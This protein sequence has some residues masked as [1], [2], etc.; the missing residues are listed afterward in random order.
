MGQVFVFFFI[1]CFHS[2]SKFQNQLQTLYQATLSTKREEK[3]RK[4]KK[5]KEK[6]KKIKREGQARRQKAKEPPAS[7]GGRQSHVEVVQEMG[8]A[9]CQGNDLPC[10][11]TQTTSTI[12]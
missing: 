11:M 6:D 4:Y 5:I 12:T 9:G 7:Y 3:I 8:N 10:H 1:K 2:E